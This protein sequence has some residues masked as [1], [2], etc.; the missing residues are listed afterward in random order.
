[1]EIEKNISF[2]TIK[3]LKEL[4]QDPLLILDRN[5]IIFES[6]SL[7]IELWKR[8][9]PGFDFFSTLDINDKKFFINLMERVEN[10]ETSVSENFSV[11]AGNEEEILF[12]I[13][14]SVITQSNGES[15]FL[16]TFRN[17]KTKDVTGKQSLIKIVDADIS[18]LINNEKIE[19]IIQEVRSSFPFTFIGKEKIKN[20]IE[21]LSEYFWIKDADS[22][23]ILVNNNFSRLVGLKS[24]QMEGKS[25]KEFIP[26][27]ITEFYQ[28]IQNYL[29]RTLNTLITKGLPIKGVML[30]D[31]YETIEIPL[32][33][34]ENK[35]IAVIG[36]ARKIE[37]ELKKQTS[38]GLDL[39]NSI[40]FFPKPA[41]LISKDG[42]ITQTSTEFCKLFG[43]E[44][45]SFNGISIVEVFTKDIAENIHYFIQSTDE[46]EH[47]QFEAKLIQS[48]SSEKIFNFSINRFY[49][50]SHILDGF[51]LFLD[52]DIA[53]L[54]L[55][56]FIRKKGKMFD[57][58]IQNHPEPIFIYDTEN[59]RFLEVN[60]TAL[61]LYGYTREVFLQM[62]LTD[63]YTPEDIQTILDTSN[64]NANAGKFTGP[65]RHK[66][67]D[68]TSVFVEIS[69]VNFK[70][71]DR[72][73]H[74]NIVRDI[75]D[76]I[77]LEQKYQIFKAVFDS[78][79]D[80][81]FITDRDGFITYSNSAVQKEFNFSSED[82]NNKAF[83]TLLREDDRGFIFNN[84]FQSGNNEPFT[85]TTE[86]KD[87]DNNYKE[88]EITSTPIL[89][90]KGEVELF[91]IVIK[92]LVKEIEVVKE[93]IKEIIVEKE[94]DSNTKNSKGT[95]INSVF[96]SSTFHEILTPINVI[97][98]FVQELS[99]SL[100]SPTEEQKESVDII[101]QNRSM[102]LETMNSLVEFTSLEQNKSEIVTEEFQITSFIESLKIECEDNF[103]RHDVEFAYGKIS[104][105]LK[106]ETDKQ[107]LLSL[108]N[109]ILKISSVITKE[110]KLYFSAYQKDDNIFIISIKDANPFIS[111]ILLNRLK[112]I[113]LQ[114]EVTLARDFGISRLTI[115]IIKKLNSLLNGKIQI[116]EREGKQ[117]EFA[118]IFP[119]KLEIT[120]TISDDEQKSEPEIFQEDIPVEVVIEDEKIKQEEYPFED[121]IEELPSETVNVIDEPI[122]VEETPQEPEEEL[123]IEQPIEMIKPSSINEKKPLDISQFST[124][125]IEDSVDS[126]I[127]FKVQ[128]KEL[129]EI[130]FAVSFEEALP[131]LTS[132]KFDFIVM[133][134]NLQGEYN[135]L[136]ALKIIHR[137]PGYEKLPIFAVTAYVLPGD[138]EKF[139][140]AGFNDFISKPI[141]KEK[142]IEVLEKYFVDR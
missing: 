63:L 78:T 48:V 92:P 101:N 32:A 84:I 133:D 49:N 67:K 66:K 14:A 129:K 50:N 57:I 72:D 132:H 103:K 109:Y 117:S 91:N 7:F 130:K 124:L 27:F 39:N 139:I 18:K 128:M 25:E 29:K 62:D 73:A 24:F 71:N 3:I 46:L 108:I 131:L 37:N 13:N 77:E 121:I 19:K 115:R 69:K 1:M 86:I 79:N 134:I 112:G 97:L 10:Y 99:E 142:M 35:L 122:L 52:E 110:K 16:F 20:E 30:A 51:L 123:I 43:S 135:G 100:Q 116:L 23:Y 127:L 82:F 68:G 74:F 95:E 38:G 137:M 33:D 80:L 141:F 56:S 98:G 59:L 9:E 55:E 34:A 85:V 64:T 89:D 61:Q 90:F 104:S 106:V 28:S 96:L 11:S 42:V 31:N 53:G 118:F 111:E 22:N 125:Y 47:F 93:I 136:D 8:G 140:A 120:E 94:V 15:L 81:I 17:K 58:L 6:N 75:N 26:S 107:K 5:G 102:L 21:K 45:D 4:I 114:D 65:W 41:I 119:L 60:E 36:F 54:D 138:R 76:R 105:S 40:K 88:F 87:S 83:T 113:L 2:D 126:Q 70:F 12:N 44:N